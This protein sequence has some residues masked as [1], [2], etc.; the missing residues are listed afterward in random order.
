MWQGSV[1]ICRGGR[2][3]GRGM[4]TER[5]VEDPPRHSGPDLLDSGPVLQVGRQLVGKLSCLDGIKEPVGT[6]PPSE[7]ESFSVH[8][9]DPGGTFVLRLFQGDLVVLRGRNFHGKFR[10]LGC[11]ATYGEEPT[12]TMEG[13]VDILPGVPLPLGELQFRFSRS[14]GPGGQNV[15][16]VET[17]VEVWI[18][19]ASSRAFPDPVRRLLIDR[20]GSRLDERGGLRVAVDESRSQFRNREMAI[21]RLARILKLALRPRKSRKVTRPTAVSRLERVRQKKL[22][23]EKKKRRS[24]SRFLGDD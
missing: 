7:E 11:F 18:P 20:L 13:R 22:K 1:V 12:K 14:G 5:P 24:L 9:D 15:N 6:H 3:P 21:E 17:R 8:P 2:V 4:L 16:K 10:I 23:G 19:I